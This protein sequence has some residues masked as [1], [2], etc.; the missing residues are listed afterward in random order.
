ML[1]F[2]V[3]AQNLITKIQ[4][5]MFFRQLGRASMGRMLNLS[6]YDKLLW[7]DLFPV[8]GNLFSTI[9][10]LSDY[11][12]SWCSGFSG[13]SLLLFIIHYHVASLF[14]SFDILKFSFFL[15][16][17]VQEVYFSSF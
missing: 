7:E 13:F 9:F 15:I 14:V 17:S 3:K 11:P 6:N 12:L 8:K 5:A 1:Y 2:H 4:I 16:H 10:S